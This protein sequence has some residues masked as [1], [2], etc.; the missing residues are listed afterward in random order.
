MRGDN[1]LV[2]AAV[3]YFKLFN[4]GCLFLGVKMNEKAEFSHGAAPPGGNSGLRK[5]QKAEKRSNKP[6]ILGQ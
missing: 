1:V 3:S 2:N 4:H 5:L 6:E